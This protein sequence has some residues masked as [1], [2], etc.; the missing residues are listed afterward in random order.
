MWYDDVNQMWKHETSSETFLRAA[1]LGWSFPKD[2][3][4]VSVATKKEENLKEE[5]HESLHTYTHTWSC[6]RAA[7]GLTKRIRVSLSDF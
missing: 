4:N 3:K 2:E 1:R 6:A 5:T 7:S